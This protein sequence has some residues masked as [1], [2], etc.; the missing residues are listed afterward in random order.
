MGVNWKFLECKSVYRL[1]RGIA[2]PY[3][4]PEEYKKLLAHTA[5]GGEGSGLM[6]KDREM[7][8]R[9]CSDLGC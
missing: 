5:E 4:P 6:L 1:K 3:L 9:Q 8:D 7:L 2:I